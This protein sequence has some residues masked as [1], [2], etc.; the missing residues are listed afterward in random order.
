MLCGDR[1]PETTANRIANVYYTTMALSLRQFDVWGFVLQRVCL[2]LG[3]RLRQF[4][5]RRAL[6]TKA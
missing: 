4:W 5:Q 2:Y 1:E 6:L 3:V